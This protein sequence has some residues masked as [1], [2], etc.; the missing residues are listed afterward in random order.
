M[1]KFVVFCAALAVVSARPQYLYGNYGYYGVVPTAVSHQSRVEVVSSPVVKSP[2]VIKTTPY[3]AYS[4]S[5]V[6]DN[7][8]THVI[9]KPVYIATPV[10]KTVVKTV[11]TVTT[12]AHAPVVS[13]VQVA[14]APVVTQSIVKTVPAAYQTVPAAYHT[15]ATSPV[16]VSKPVVATYAQQAPAVYAAQYTPTV[17]AAQHNQAVYAQHVP[18]V[19]SYGLGPY[20]YVTV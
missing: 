1:F 6:V 18:A 2:V 11:P 10:R 4:E 9:N 15:V 19:T 7:V 13:A 5:V 20:G 3:G 17:Y 16:V 8:G 14:H 12:Y